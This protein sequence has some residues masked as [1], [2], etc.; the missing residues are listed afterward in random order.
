MQIKAKEAFSAIRIKKGFSIT[1]LAHKMGVNPSVV[2]SIEKGNNI[3]PETA[4]KAYTALATNFD[5]IFCIQNEEE[6]H[7]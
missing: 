6:I 2:S 5:D 7:L 4:K 3:R 1:G